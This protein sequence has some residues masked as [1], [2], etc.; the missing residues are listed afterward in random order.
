MTISLS[1]ASQTQTHPCGSQ[2]ES[3]RIGVH[4]T[5]NFGI[6]TCMWFWCKFSVLKLREFF[7]YRKE[8]GEENAT[9]FWQLH[10]KLRAMSMW[11][12]SEKISFFPLVGLA[13]I[14]WCLEVPGSVFPK[15]VLEVTQSFRVTP[16]NSWGFS[17]PVVQLPK[18]KGSFRRMRVSG[19][20]PGECTES[21][22]EGVEKLGSR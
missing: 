14:K 18:Y 5:E 4:L 21:P 9:N 8:R 10:S 12:F 6:S 11:L 16:F 19:W 1:R 3:R 7:S 22:A 17:C 13:W 2:D 20:C 15:F